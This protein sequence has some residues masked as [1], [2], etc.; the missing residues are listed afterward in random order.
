MKKNLSTTEIADLHQ[1]YV[2]P[3]YAPK[4][5]LV[6]GLGA[7]VWD[8]EGKRYLDFC[9]GIA[10]T[11]IGHSHPRL[12]KAIQEQAEQLLHVSNLF[13]NPVQPQLAAA[14]ATCSGL[15]GA[16]CFFCN[17]GAEA[18]E[19]IIKLARLWGSKQGRHE[20]ITFKQ[21]FHGRT[22]ATLTATGQ[23]KVKHGFG[24]LP[25]GFVYADYN[26][27]DSVQKLMGPQTV[28]VMVEALQGEGGVIPSN[29]EF[30]PGLR[31]LCD[32][33][34]ILLLCD[35]VQAGVGRTGMWFGF[36]QYGVQPDA[37]SLA[38]GLGGGFPIGGIVAG[39]QLA[40]TFH[41]GHH[42]TTFGGTPLGSA[43]ALAVIETIQDEGLLKHAAD[44]GNMFMD[45]LANVVAKYPAW[46]EGVRGIGLMNGLVLK[47]PAAR[48]QQAVFEQGLLSIAT[49]QR[50]LRLLPPM[51]VSMEEVDL[52]LSWIDTACKEVNDEMLALIEAI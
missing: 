49:A 34:G 45:G 48:L 35:E 19:G 51:I 29:P 1:T 23:D 41:P 47:V 36:Q 26:D 42:A 20:I 50:V 7:W 21:S 3:T 40:N 38:K 4:T 39:E 22:L 2:M 52:A 27:L 30:L 25:E 9:S 44:M 11:N 6:K 5:A 12:V 31:A 16:K 10:V 18:N 17:S 13:Y 8:A 14:L 32:E 43:A 33:A 28:A 46:I 37:F 24:P 15:T